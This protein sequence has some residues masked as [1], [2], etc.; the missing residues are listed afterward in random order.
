ME[1]NQREIY[2]IK[3]KRMKITLQQVADG[4]NVTRATVSRWETGVL[5][6]PCKY[7]DYIDS[8]VGK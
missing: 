5:P 4:L 1:L 8:L 7:K 3:R 6:L 2:Q